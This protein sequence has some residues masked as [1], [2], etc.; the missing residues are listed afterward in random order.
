M[1]K[2][3]TTNT[4]VTETSMY[5]NMTVPTFHNTHDIGVTKRRPMKPW[6]KDGINGGPS[7]LSVVMT[8]LTKPANF[9]RWEGSKDENSSC[10]RESLCSEI[11]R[12]LMKRGI[13][14]R[15][16]RDIRNRIQNIYYGYKKA[17]NWIDENEQITRN[18]LLERGVPADQ[19][20]LVIEGKR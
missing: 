11:N 16:N 6:D 17:Q 4:I 15:N 18:K 12:L 13:K 14:H 8:W 10:T 9:S 5:F 2:M 19:L 7:S 1:N 3:A 20:D